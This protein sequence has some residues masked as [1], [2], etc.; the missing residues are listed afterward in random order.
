MKKALINKHSFLFPHEEEYRLTMCET[1]ENNGI[2][3]R[4]IVQSPVSLRSFE[5]IKNEILHELQFPQLFEILAFFGLSLMGKLIPKLFTVWESPIPYQ[6]TS[7]GD[8]I[9]QLDLN[10]PFNEKETVPDWAVV[11]FCILLPIVFLGISGLLC[12]PSGDAHASLC[13][14]FVAVGCSELL[15][16]LV[17]L[18][19]GRFRPN[20]YNMCGFDAD[21]KECQLQ[22]LHRLHD[23][24]KSFPSGHASVAFSSML[25]LSFYLTGKVGIQRCAP[26]M[27]SKLYY[28]LAWTPMLV[29]VFIAASRVHD[30]YHHPADIVG[31][32]LIGGVCAVMAHGMW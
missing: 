15:T 32:C 7:T 27:K 6:E 1:T 18:Y 28:M 20:F 3:A 24:R 2:T 29:A 30:F 16:D 26:S 11:V 5:E 14:L 23:A 22:D 10:Y 21:S 25:V 13:T 8:V 9:L 31:G 12:G 17:K 19:C 4:S